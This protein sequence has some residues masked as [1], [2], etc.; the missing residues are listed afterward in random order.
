MRSCSAMRIGALMALFSATAHAD[1]WLN[2]TNVAG[3]MDYVA[4]QWP[5][6][7]DLDAGTNGMFYGR[8]YELNV[9]EDD[10]ANPAILAQWGYGAFASDPRSVDWTW[11][12]AAYNVQIASD[13]EYFIS[14]AASVPG[15]YSYTFRFSQDAGASWTLADWGGAGASA[16]LDFDP[17]LTGTMTVLPEPALAG[18]AAAALPLLARRRRRGA[19]V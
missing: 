2:E 4:L 5:A 7:I 9:T 8:V 15:T 16:G 6:T 10:G 14:A 17:S 18:T 19:A 13:D 3:E 12:N 11:L 1:V